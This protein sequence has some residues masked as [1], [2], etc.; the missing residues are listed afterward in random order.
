M[1]AG[2]DLAGL[3]TKEDDM[4]DEGAGVSAVHLHHRPPILPS[5]IRR[6][7]PRAE[8]EAL[9][10]LGAYPVTD[11]S[12]AVGR[13]YT[14]A[15]IVPLHGAVPAI[16]GAALTVKCPPGDN[17]GVVK[18]IAMAKPG[19]VLVIDA[20]GFTEWCLGGHQL[21]LNAVRRGA[22]GFVVNGAYRDAVEA[23]RDGLALYGRGVSAWSGPKA[24]PFEI[25]V[26]ICCG[27]VIVEPGDAV[28]ASADGI[29]VAP[30][31]RLDAIL[32]HLD[33]AAAKGALSMDRDAEEVKVEK[34]IEAVDSHVDAAFARG[35]G[36]F[37]D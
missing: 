19:D 20:Q 8:A 11:V 18:A 13:M 24:G 29:V 22:L 16:C 12:D 3:T 6:D 28:H 37:I 21:L 9:A 35:A 32:A 15:G 2:R 4:N 10:R 23:E 36:E 17:L 26:P 33:A 30:R 25:N 1:G 7:P 14:M 34:F 27:G 5:L 31:V